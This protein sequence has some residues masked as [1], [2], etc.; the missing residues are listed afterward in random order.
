MRKVIS[1]TTP[2]LSLLKIGKLSVLKD[3]YERVYIPF[4][5]YEEIEKGKEKPYYQDI[6]DVDWIE[7]RK[8][9]S[10]K[11]RFYF[12]DLDKGEAEVL[13]LANEMGADL[14]IIDE[15]LG[16]RYAKKME[17]QLTGTL[18]ILLKAKQ[19][20]FL[21]EIQKLLIQ[22]QEKG[23]WFNPQLIEKVLQLANEKND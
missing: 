15:I 7:I 9:K 3:L 13:I 19:R 6:K 22:L 12:M 8:I 2:I 5:V 20:G 1:N 16:R 10:P 11:S 21:P 18:G 17:L 23:S 4:A 14:V